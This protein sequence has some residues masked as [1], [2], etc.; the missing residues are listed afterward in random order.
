[1][2]LQIGSEITPTGVTDTQTWE[3][4]SQDELVKRLESLDEPERIVSIDQWAPHEG[5]EDVQVALDQISRSGSKFT[6]APY[7]ENGKP[8]AYL[9]FDLEESDE[10]VEDLL[11]ILEENDVSATFFTHAQYL[12][13]YPDVIEMIEKEGHVVASG[14]DRRLS[15]SAASEAELIN[16]GEEVKTRIESITDAAPTCIRPDRSGLL[17]QNVDKFSSFGSDILFFDVDAHDRYAQDAG[18][19]SAHLRSS[20]DPGEILLLHAGHA[21]STVTNDAVLQYISESEQD[22][23]QFQSLPCSR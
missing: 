20:T 23:W 12:E 3:V 21:N 5:S 8:V 10:G 7:F 13:E 6:S 9:T 16:A 4:L 18:D 15:L 14:L 22:E 2:W 11:E 17:P 1:M 19:V